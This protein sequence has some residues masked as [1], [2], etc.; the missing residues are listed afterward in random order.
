MSSAFLIASAAESAPKSEPL[1]V[2]ALRQQIRRNASDAILF[3]ISGGQAEF[4]R[5]N[6]EY[7]LKA[8]G[9]ITVKLNAASIA[10]A[11]RAE[12][13]PERQRLLLQMAE[14]KARDRE[15]WPGARELAAILECSWPFIERDLFRLVRK[16]H[17][18]IGSQL[19]DGRSVRRIELVAAGIATA[20][21]PPK[22]A[23]RNENRVGGQ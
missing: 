9:A 2:T 5:L 8:S 6:L 10:T 16:G 20:L 1:I 4:V 3:R 17:I 14:L 15:V 19:C 13:L 21:P 23:A 11:E 12:R 22:K 7:A 18:R